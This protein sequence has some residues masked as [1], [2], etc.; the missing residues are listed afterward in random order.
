MHQ[1]YSKGVPTP[2]QVVIVL[3]LG[4]E[5]VCFLNLSRFAEAIVQWPHATTLFQRRG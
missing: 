1:K 3:L 2:L 5:K 4:G